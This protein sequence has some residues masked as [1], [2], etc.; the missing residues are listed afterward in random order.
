MEPSG[1]DRRASA[2][3]DFATFVWFKRIDDGANPS[4]EGVARSCD[5]SET[6][7]GLVTAKLLPAGAQLFLKLVASGA[8]VSVIARVTHCRPVDN[9]S[10]RLGLKI[11]CIPPTDRQTWMW[12]ASQ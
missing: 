1:R 9:G 2:R 3:Y 11:E 12:L 8:S 5:I 4:E 10:F 6:G 7:V